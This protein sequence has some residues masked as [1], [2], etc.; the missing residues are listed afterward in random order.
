MP[1][2]G[3]RSERRALPRLAPVPVIPIGSVVP[4]IEHVG[5]IFPLHISPQSKLSEILCTRF[6]QYPVQGLVPSK[7]TIRRGS[8]GSTLVSMMESPDLGERD[9]LSE[10]LVY[11]VRTSQTIGSFFVE[12]VLAPVCG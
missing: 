4:S 9:D 10:I 2:T 6:L 11:V 8:S 12:R 5:V 3:S 1:S 7:N